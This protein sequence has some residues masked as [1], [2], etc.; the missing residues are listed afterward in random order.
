MKKKSLPPRAA[1]RQLLRCEWDF[2][3]V[4]D[5]ELEACCRWEYARE[6]KFVRAA[7]QL[8]RELREGKLCAAALTDPQRVTL[9]RMDD[10]CAAPDMSA[11][12]YFK[13]PPFPDPWQ[14]A[15][16]WL[17]SNP[18]HD[19]KPFPFNGATFQ[20]L[21]RHCTALPWWSQAK[22]TGR[23]LHGGTESLFVQI[24]W[25]KWSNRKIKE[26]FC[27]WVDRSRPVG[28]AEQSGRGRKPNTE[29]R[30]KLDRLGLLRLRHRYS[31][32]EAKPFLDTL[33]AGWIEKRTNAGECNREASKACDHFR[34]LFPF[35]TRNELPLSWPMK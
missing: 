3:S 13:S 17:P 25:G 8:K 1:S 9:E 29:W 16:L 15:T 24:E 18:S 19:T 2:A 33:K 22:G 35:H 23:V 12:H 27:E 31:F 20:V 34:E 30:A 11:D 10:V 5:S 28:I 14:A 6:S 21:D 4:P 26:A 32:S 7:A